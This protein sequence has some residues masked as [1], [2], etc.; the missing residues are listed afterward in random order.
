MIPSPFVN[1]LALVGARVRMFELFEKKKGEMKTRQKG[2]ME[3]T[4]GM[5]NE[6]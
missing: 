6:E 4:E 3:R 5:R 1:T 2:E